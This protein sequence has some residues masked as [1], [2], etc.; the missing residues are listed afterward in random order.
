MVFARLYSIREGFEMASMM[1]S[2]REQ[3]MIYNPEDTL[4]DDRTYNMALGGSVMYGLILNIIICVTLG[5]RLTFAVYRNP[6]V[7]LY[8]IIGYVVCAIAGVFMSS[9]SKSP[10]VSFIGYNLVCVPLGLVLSLTVSAYVRAGAGNIVLQA[11]AYT[12]ISA[13]CMIVLS[14]VFPDFFSGLGKILFGSLIGLLVAGI[15]SALFFPGAYN[16]ITW[17]GALIFALYI[18]Y[19]YWRAQQ[20]PKTLDNA[21]DCSLDIYL[22]IINLFIRILRILGSRGSSR[23]R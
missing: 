22:D 3:R 10:V 14:I 7:A 12:A 13:G 19:D 20:F 23:R 5:N 17:I 11:I 2:R 8:L 15:I 6:M 9:R 4:L 1:Q 21:I 16:I 18:G